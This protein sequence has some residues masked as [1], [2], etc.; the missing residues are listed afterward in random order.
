MF[1]TRVALTALTLLSSVFSFAAYTLLLKFL[2]NTVAVDR[3]F[4]ASSVPLSVAGVTT[5]VLLYL[6][7]PQLARQDG[8]T[9]EATL[10]VL[11]LAVVC[12]CALCAALAAVCT[13]AT[14]SHSFWALLF[15]FSNIAGMLVLATLGTC[16]AQVRG[17]YLAT[18][19]A[20]LLTAAGLLAGTVAGIV[21]RLEWLLVIGQWLG[22]AAALSWLTL[23][24]RLPLRSNPKTDWLRCVDVLAPMRRYVAMIALGTIAFTLF[25]PIDAAL[26]SQLD[27]GSVSI[28]SYAQRVLVAVSTVVSM[29]AHA[30]AAR[31]SHDALRTGG[32]AALRR[33]ANREC[34]QIVGFGLASWVAYQAGGDHLLAA[35]FS[36]SKMS[37]SDQARLQECVRWMLIGAG[38]MAA[39]P[40]LFRVFYTAGVYRLPAVL[41]AATALGYAAIAL[42]LL[43]R[44]GLLAMAYAYA[45][46]WWLTLAAA[47]LWL[48]SRAMAP[49]CQ[50]PK[51]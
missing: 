20:P 10:R 48:N 24:L 41:G 9:Q 17:Q 25:Q 51:A 11:A 36:A 15:G 18:G 19:V 6:L 30:I 5:G 46:V 21:F 3:L 50:N 42:L 4:F 31:T 7:P 49:P 35:L 26:C 12:L 47:L 28:M 39:M 14:Q 32:S 8:A 40:Y 13:V 33:L 2:G 44:F 38:P 43:Q 45:L 22:A 23:A 34:R 29:G 16:M 1:T 27:G 37:I